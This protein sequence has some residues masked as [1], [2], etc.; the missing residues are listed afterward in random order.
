MCLRGASEVQRE[1]LEKDGD[2]DLRAYVVW[3]PKV[4][5]KE[6]NVPAATRFV[7]DPRAHHFWDG[8]GV[9]LKNYRPVLPIAKDVWDV[10]M[11]Y[12]RDARWDAE[13]PPEPE[14]WMHQLDV[15]NAPELDGATFA[16]RVKS[17]E[18]K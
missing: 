12:R 1:L 17:L 7:P 5:G 11:V 3:V 6:Q 15:K 10:Y 4:G 2:P 9:L 8:E 13:G 18:V 14:F 16:A